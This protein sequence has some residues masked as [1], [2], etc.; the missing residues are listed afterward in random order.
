[1]GTV[2]TPTNRNPIDSREGPIRAASIRN[3]IGE[4]YERHVQASIKFWTST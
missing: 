4:R 1:M 2:G 3:E